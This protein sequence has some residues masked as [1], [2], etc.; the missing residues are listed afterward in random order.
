MRRMCS[1]E[2]DWHSQWTI[3]ACSQFEARSAYYARKSAETA[4][5]DLSVLPLLIDLQLKLLKA[6]WK[7]E[8]TSG[9]LK[10]LL[11]IHVDCELG[12]LWQELPGCG[13]HQ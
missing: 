11:K 3:A 1:T 13:Q 7:L 10:E 12:E 8:I 2:A 6:A 9:T 5:L 4:E